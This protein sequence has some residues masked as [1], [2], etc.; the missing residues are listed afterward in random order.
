MN[1]EP[2]KEVVF[3]TEVRST[4]RGSRF[5]AILVIFHFLSRRF[6]RVWCGF[7]LNTIRSHLNPHK[8][9]RSLPSVSTR[10]TCSSRGER[11]V[12]ENHRLPCINQATVILFSFFGLFEKFAKLVCT[13]SRRDISRANQYVWPDEQYSIRGRRWLRPAN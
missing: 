10:L 3:G 4:C 8:S 1:V 2:E 12:K 6:V 9:P 11:G 7:E 13:S 5:S